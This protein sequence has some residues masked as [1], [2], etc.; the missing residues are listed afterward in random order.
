MILVLVEEVELFVLRGLVKVWGYFKV[1]VFMFFGCLYI[2]LYFVEFLFNN[3]D[4]LV[5]FDF[6]D[7]FVDIVGDGY[8]FVIC[9]VE[10]LDFSF[11]VWCLVLVY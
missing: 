2:V 10:L 7:E 1:V 3:G 11:V 5:N 9:I 8:D 4:F 6:F